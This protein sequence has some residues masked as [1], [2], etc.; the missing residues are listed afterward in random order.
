MLLAG[1]KQ[2]RQLDEFKKTYIDIL[3]QVDA[4][5]AA[6]YQRKLYTLFY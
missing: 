4:A 3:K 5:L 2:D 6:T 1:L